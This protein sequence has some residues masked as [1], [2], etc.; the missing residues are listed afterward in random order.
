MGFRTQRMAND[1]PLWSKVR[2]DP[3]SMGQRLF[4]TFS[5]M[6]EDHTISAIKISQDFRLL[7]WYL[8]VGRVWG[9]ILDEDDVFPTSETSFGVSKYSYPT[10]VGTLN[11]VD[12]TCAR[13]TEI[14]EFMNAAPDR[15]VSQGQSSYSTLIC[16]TSASPYSVVDPPWP[17][18][19]C[20]T[21]QGSTFYSRPN[22]RVQDLAYTG[23]HVVQIAGTDENDVP[24]REYVEVLDD[25]VYYTR[26]IFKTVAEVVLEGFDGSTVVSWFPEQNPHEIDPYRSA[27]F[28]DFEGQ[29]KLSLSSQVVGASTYSYVEYS[30]D[31]LKLGEQ[32]RRPS[33]E[34]PDNTEILAE[35]VL[36]DS[37]GDPY[38]AVDLAI[39]HE[40]S[41]LYILDDQGR[42][43]VYDH[44]LSAFDYVEEADVETAR[45]HLELVPLRHRS[46]Y[47]D[48]EYIYT[49]FVR[50]RNGIDR[51]QIKRIAPDGTT[52]YL[53]ADKS[54][55]SAGAAWI[56]APNPNA[57]RP[58]HTWSD[59]RFSTTYN[60]LGQWEY[61]CT[62]VSAR[63]TTVYTTAV[64]ASY[65]QALRTIDTNVGSPTGLSF[66][67][68]GYV[69]ITDGSDVHWFEEA[70]DVWLADVRL[71]QVLMR[72]QYDQVEVAY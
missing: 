46:K 52:E 34:A 36:L 25:G 43:H 19:L 72:S 53:Q 31:R 42:L 27:V 70:F 9:F 13:S 68:E 37:S 30:S 5:E 63:D 58:E 40:T 50:N 56:A 2:K 45:T 54:T 20:I 26:N 1:F 65:L 61:S 38:T 47:G 57:E 71:G 22:N 62:T 23:R 4:S 8:G 64:M 51:I 69:A 28:D 12:Y 59:F 21:V 10:I 6:L 29:L 7:K 17:E 3:S 24:I 48:A 67:K 32:Y 60:Q 39:N 33:I 14:V 41:R 44:E 16:W 55:W 18:R 11:G 15:L 35:V 49:D 66:S